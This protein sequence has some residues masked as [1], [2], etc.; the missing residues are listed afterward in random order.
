[1]N[2]R[3]QLAVV[4]VVGKGQVIVVNRKSHVDA[5]KPHRMRRQG[6][7]ER[8]TIISVFCVLSRLSAN[9]M[10]AP[11]ADLSYVAQLQFAGR[12]KAACGD[13][14]FLQRQEPPGV[15]E[16]IHEWPVNRGLEPRSL[17]KGCV[18]VANGCVITPYAGSEMIVVPVLQQQSLNVRRYAVV[19][20]C[21]K[22][23]LK[24]ESLIR[25]TVFKN[26]ARS[27][28]PVTI[29]GATDLPVSQ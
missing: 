8:L 1:M 21:K 18:V 28:D 16:G 6:D 15:V 13:A 23:L 5:V 9:Q 20:C 3:D 11:I 4:Y 24:S 25:Q 14:D 29:T 19:R 27:G 10:I 7:V 2:S 26:A 17:V 22:Y 12:N